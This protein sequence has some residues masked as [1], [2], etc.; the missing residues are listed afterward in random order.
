[1]T[2]TDIPSEGTR[3]MTCAKSGRLWRSPESPFHECAVLLGRVASTAQDCQVPYGVPTSA[4]HGDHVVDMEVIGRSTSCAA[5]VAACEESPDVTFGNDENAIPRQPDLSLPI[6]FDERGLVGVV[7][8]ASGSASLLGV[9]PVPVPPFG[10]RRLD[11][12]LAV[13]AVAVTHLPRICRSSS[14]AGFRPGGSTG[15]TCC[16]ELAAAG[17]RR[18]PSRRLICRFTGLA[19]RPQPVLRPRKPVELSR[20]S[21]FLAPRTPLGRERIHSSNGA[22]PLRHSL[23]WD[24]RNTSRSGGP[25]VMRQLVEYLDYPISPE[26]QALADGTVA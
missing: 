22:I 24:W 17:I 13:R 18:V 26:E 14:A 19:P 5:R 23:D 4:G 2:G 12:A 1:M 10:A 7:P 9:R 25:L 20:R 8:L 3:R 21:L 11:I 16:I 15:G 6:S